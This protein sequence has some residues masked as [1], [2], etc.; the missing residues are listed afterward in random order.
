MCRSE[1]EGGVWSASDFPCAGSVI[2][3]SAVNLAD[4]FYFNDTNDRSRFGGGS[5]AC[6]GR[7]WAVFSFSF[8]P[9]LALPQGSISQH[10]L[11]LMVGWPISR[12]HQSGNLFCNNE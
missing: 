4:L 2:T 6:W 10:S 9:C 1:A 8:C 11:C 5:A 3:K 12:S 7:I